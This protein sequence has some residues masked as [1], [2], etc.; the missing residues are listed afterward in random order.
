MAGATPTVPRGAGPS[1]DASS[2][3]GIQAVVRSR[4]FEVRRCYERGKMDEPELKGRVTVRIAI[5]PAGGVASALVESSSLGNS[6]VEGCIVDA[7]RAW[8]FPAPAGSTPLVIS[9]PFNLR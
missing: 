1:G 2:S 7:V 3:I 8:P 5:P 4:L 9:Y 6:R